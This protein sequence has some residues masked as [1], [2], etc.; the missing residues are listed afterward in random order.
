M[1]VEQEI[2]GNGATL[3]HHGPTGPVL[4]YPRSVNHFLHAVATVLTMGLWAFFWL[5][6]VL[7]RKEVRVQVRI[8]EA[9]HVWA[10]R[11]GIA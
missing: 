8:D 11:G 10:T 1:A 5:I 4:S 2:L 6:C 3:V 9:G 7:D